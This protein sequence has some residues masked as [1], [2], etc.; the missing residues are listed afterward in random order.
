MA[1][2]TLNQ[3][4][5]VKIT[6]IFLIYAFM[7]TICYF[8]LSTPVDMIIDGFE[9]I[10]AGDETATG[11]LAQFIPL[12]RDV[13]TIFWAL[14]VALPITWFIM[15]IFSREPAWYYQRRY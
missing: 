11:K 5:I 8:I 13:L 4:N 3:D 6:V 15:K 2:G 12:Y 1:G 14:F 10:D 9:G 7:V